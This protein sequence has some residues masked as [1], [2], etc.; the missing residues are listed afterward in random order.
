MK[1]I[2]FTLFFFLAIGKV[3]GQYQ[4]D[5]G[6]WENGQYKYYYYDAHDVDKLL[7]IISANPQINLDWKVYV[8][9]VGGCMWGLG[10]DNLLH[11][12]M[13]ILG[14]YYSSNYP[15]ITTIDLS[16]CK[17]LTILRCGYS[18]LSSLNVSGC[19]SLTELYCPTNKLTKL[20]VSGC[21]SLT[22]LTCGGNQ[23]ISL[24]VSGLTSLTT[25][26]CDP[27]SLNASDCTSL[28]TLTCNVAS[29]NVSG[30]TSLTELYCSTNKLTKLNVSGLTSL[31]TLSCE[32]THSSPPGGNLTSL[33]V[34]GCTNL[35]TLDCNWNQLTTL[36][37]SG[38]RS[39]TTLNCSINPL[40]SLNASGCTSLTGLNCGTINGCLLTSLDVSGCT[41]LTELDASGCLYWGIDHDCTGTGNQLTSINVNGCTSLVKL[42]C[43]GNQLTSLDVSGLTS[44]TKL[45]CSLNQLTSLDVS[46]FANLTYLEC[47]GNQL[48]SLDVSG[49][50]SLN[51]LGCSNVNPL[52]SLNVSGCINLTDLGCVSNQLDSLNVSGCINLTDLEC[53]S[54]QLT[55]LNVS[56]C[57]NL[58]YLECSGNQLTSLNV[59]G[60]MSLS[61]LHCYNNRLTS[62]NVSGCTNL[63][64][65]TCY[66]NQLTLLN[67]NGCI[68]LD[69]LSCYNNQLSDENLPSFYGLNITSNFNLLG[70]KGFHESAI[71]KLADN[72]P[73]ISY[74]QIL[75][76]KLPEDSLSVSPD[77]LNF[78]APGMP[79]Q[80]FE[81]TSNVD[82]TVSC[83][84]TWVIVFPTSGTNNGAVTVTATAN[85]DSKQRTA[86]ITIEGNGVTTQTINV[87]QDGL[88]CYDVAP[89]LTT[90][91]DQKAPYYND[92]LFFGEK[93]PTGCA[94][95]AMAQIMKF[96]NSPSQ[97][98]RTIPAYTT[99]S[100]NISISAITGNTTYDWNNMAN[101]YN[102][103]SSS[104][105]NAAVAKLMYECGVSINMDYMPSGS[106]ANI[107]ESDDGNYV[108]PIVALAEYFNYDCHIEIFWKGDY[109][110][111]DWDT[112]LREELEAGRP[113][114]YNGDNGQTGNNL[115]VH[116]FVCDGYR[117]S[118]ST[119]H[120][121]WGWSGDADGY[122]PI[123]QLNP[124][125]RTGKTHDFSHHQFVI[126]N[127]KPN[128]N[129]YFY[130]TSADGINT[131]AVA[132][133]T[134]SGGCI[135]PNGS[136][137][138]YKSENKP[139]V[140]A[141][142]R[143]YEI[144][145]VL[146]D[147][148]PDATAKE[149]GYY[150]FKGISKNHTIEVT[151]KESAT[152]I[153]DLHS[154][155]ISIYPNPIKNELFINSASPIKKV[156]IY[157]L[158]GSLALSD[159]NFT[160][161]ISISSLYKGIYLVK[162]Y[163]NNGVV[164]SKIVKE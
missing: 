153:K 101:V 58:T 19:T 7:A 29:L 38:C 121:N 91:W 104:Q 100:L 52:T 20:N 36:D 92:C 112:M 24:D 72:L 113:I 81:V 56:D 118:D 119:F 2:I 6:Y 109:S 145:R 27:S 134:G 3:V 51:F 69:Y 158:T 50:T 34:S 28:T 140:F 31:I 107:G 103:S 14:N 12:D 40:T 68:N 39:L 10:N 102:S 151:F 18:Q 157:T 164:V 88:I 62:L 79:S 117:C 122:F 53:G 163:T 77:S 95:T 130:A 13:L 26:S 42:D 162:V 147:G 47:S 137:Y 111:S 154:Q 155:N 64:F 5:F 86:I 120:F 150:I 74:D 54:N 127:I 93:Y 89:L 139:Y 115:E 32:G 55:S 105:Q 17:N 99:E 67:V 133:N 149:N 97:R 71:R 160:G 84:S 110:D 129:G 11:L 143:G 44:L 8:Q 142:N 146:V 22:S 124:K 148:I 9:G 125:D 135:I 48:T 30:C 141:A 37:V 123:S 152:G 94:A 131:F 41:S 4:A 1:Q 66:D 15:L 46:G 116:A 70:N 96:W 16:G 108:G 65:L 73:N 144:D 49:L 57:I 132:G 45:D 25:L 82:W 78:S 159:N 33:D 106:G 59:S 76:D 35:T 90:N 138:V 23:L 126:I 161:K 43:H 75:Y 63:G 128:P 87:T 156:E 60:Y 98:T 136:S 80:T 114:L 21:T 85:T 83:D 61:G